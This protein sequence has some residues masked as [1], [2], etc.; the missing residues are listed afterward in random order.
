MG[1]AVI[2][3]ASVTADVGTRA[4]TNPIV[5][6]DTGWPPSYPL[7]MALTTAISDYDFDAVYHRNRFGGDF[8]ELANEV[9]C[10]LVAMAFVFVMQH[11]ND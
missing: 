3:A 2:P 6:D 1:E 5:N 4:V 8:D 7:G 9:V 10:D 11:G